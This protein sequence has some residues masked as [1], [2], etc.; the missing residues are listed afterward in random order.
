MA[1]TEM[2]AGA[3][4][5]WQ[6]ERLR[7]GDAE[8][9]CPLSIGAGWNQVAADWLNDQARR[10]AA[11]VATSIAAKAARGEPLAQA[12]KESGMT[13]PP[14]QSIGARRIQIASQN[15]HFTA[16]GLLEAARARNL[17]VGRATVFRT[18]EVLE[19]LG[20]VERLDLPSGEHPLYR[21]KP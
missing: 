5:A 18:L 12:V 9:L 14:V 21:D 3:A 11:A 10:R 13:L 7:A 20:A 17:T 8:G 2:P 1:A 16:T 4:S 15:G 19:A 6:T